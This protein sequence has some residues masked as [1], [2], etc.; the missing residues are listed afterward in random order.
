M[1]DDPR[2]LQFLK[3]S[4]GTALITVLLGGA[5]GNLITCS[6]Q[7]SQ[8]EREF[9]R[10]WLEARGDQA[11]EA[12]KDYL[13]GQ[14]ETINKTFGLLGR[15]ISGSE[16]LITLTK[17]EFDISNFSGDEKTKMIKQRTNIRDEFNRSDQEWRQ[18]R[19]TIGLLLRYYHQGDPAVSEA[20]RTVMQTVSDHSDCARAVYV[21]GDQSQASTCK[22][23]RLALTDALEELNVALEESRRYA[24]EGWESP[25]V[26]KRALEA[27]AS[28]LPE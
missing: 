15:S 14:E 19:E 11:L 3:T 24:W 1:N 18:T 21:S 17:P 7:S 10:N 26:M 27:N 16:D 25:E 12:Y 4:G 6:I 2:W 9:R 22:E 5:F 13:K 23:M 8:A 28:S 20:W